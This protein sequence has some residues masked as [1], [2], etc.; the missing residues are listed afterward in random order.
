MGKPNRF[1]AAAVAALLVVVGVA[2]AV[3]LTRTPAHFEKGSA[4]ATVQGYL[5]AIADQNPTAAGAYLD[6]AGPCADSDVEMAYLPEQF[7]AVLVS[8][9]VGEDSATVRVTIT[10]GNGEP[11]GGGYSHEEVFRLVRSGGDWRLSGAPWPMG[12]CEGMSP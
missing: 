2:T 1:L 4:V 11:F 12:W 6:P 9:D 10:E 3:A 7:R 8:Q 5:D